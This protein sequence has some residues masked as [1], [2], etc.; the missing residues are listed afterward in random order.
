VT[1]AV[2]NVLSPAWILTTTD[3]D[4]EVTRG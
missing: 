4:L 2:L 1:D 3:G